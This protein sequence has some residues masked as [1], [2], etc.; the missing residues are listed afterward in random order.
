MIYETHNEKG[1]KITGNSMNYNCF[2]LL[3]DLCI[4]FTVHTVVVILEFDTFR[5]QE[6]GK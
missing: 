5:K 6:I 4:F 2:L 1:D 3:R